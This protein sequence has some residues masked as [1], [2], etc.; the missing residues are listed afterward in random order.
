MVPP[1]PPRPR[2]LVVGLWLMVVAGSGGAIGSVVQ[3]IVWSL[4]SKT[5]PATLTPRIFD[6][7]MMGFTLVAVP[8]G[9]LA[10]L[11]WRGSDIALILV[12]IGTSVASFRIPYLIAEAIAQL[13]QRGALRAD[14]FE[15]A[16][17]RFTR[18]GVSGF[19]AAVWIATPILVAFI[20]RSSR[21]WTRTAAAIRSVTKRLKRGQVVQAMPPKVYG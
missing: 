8:M 4:T 2:A 10:Y 17:L 13:I 5:A 14:F 1:I 9:V 3:A 6:V 21:R 19:N 16:N 18:P 11:V 12:I 15:L 20:M 7:L